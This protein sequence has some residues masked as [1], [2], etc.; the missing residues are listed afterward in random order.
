MIKRFLYV[1]GDSGMGKTMYAKRAALARRA[2][3][4]R[5]VTIDPNGVYDARFG[6]RVDIAEACRR[7]RAAGT[8]GP[9]ALVVSARFGEARE[10]G[11]VFAACYNAG[12]M[13]VV[14]DEAQKWARANT[15]CDEFMELNETGRNR[16]VD[17]IT[18]SQ[19][20]TTLH[21]AIG[22]N[23]DTLVCFRLSKPKYALVVAEDYFH[24]R[25]LAPVIQRLS[26]FHYLRTTVDGSDV[27][28]GVVEP[29]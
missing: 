26:Q 15:L 1:H 2:A 7:M 24:R 3:G 4:S 12:N 27:Q 10:M 16:W 5:L 20:P 22:T 29:L 17:L 8:Y 21:P 23:Y 11:R 14:V 25:D 6:D 19:T 28:A 9:L 13:A 18:T